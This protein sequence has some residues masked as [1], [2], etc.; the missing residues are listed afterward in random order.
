MLYIVGLGLG[1]ERDITLR[2][3][4]EVKQCDKV[5]IKSYTSLLSFGISSDGL[6]TPEKLYGRPVILADREMVE[7]KAD[8]ILSTARVS[9]VA[10]LVVGDPFGNYII[11][12]SLDECYM[13]VYMHC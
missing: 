10:F 4:E 12:S 13:Y 2:G 7:E 3:L 6:S 9:D 8:E 1:D 11:S 5:Y